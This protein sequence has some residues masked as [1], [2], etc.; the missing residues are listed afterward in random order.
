SDWDEAQELV[1]EPLVQ[2]DRNE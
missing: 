1:V 2:G